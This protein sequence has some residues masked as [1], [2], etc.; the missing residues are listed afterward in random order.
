MITSHSGSRTAGRRGD[1]LPPGSVEPDITSGDAN[2]PGEHPDGGG[3]ARTVGPE[4][5]VHPSLRYHQVQPIHGRERSEEL[6]Q[7]HHL[8]HIAVV[9]ERHATRSVLGCRAQSVEGCLWRDVRPMVNGWGS[10]VARGREPAACSSSAVH[11]PRVPTTTSPAKAFP[12]H[13]E[14]PRTDVAPRMRIS[15]KTS[16]PGGPARRK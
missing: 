16:A 15:M 4:E 5:T 10:S 1:Y 2:D 6:A 3:L 8:D 14:Y 9:N 12:D 13:L 7:P 11:P